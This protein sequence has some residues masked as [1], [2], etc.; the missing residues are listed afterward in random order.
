MNLALFC[1]GQVVI[2]WTTQVF[3]IFDLI[4]FMVETG[5]YN[6]GENRR[7]TDCFILSMRGRWSQS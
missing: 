5:A 2:L 4:V 7:I 3:D 1:R 6:M